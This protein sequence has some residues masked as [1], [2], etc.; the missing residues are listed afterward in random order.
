MSLET[1]R[2]SDVLV[3]ILLFFS[4]LSFNTSSAPET[5]MC[6]DQKKNETKDLKPSPQAVLLR[7]SGRATFC[8]LLT[9]YLNSPPASSASLPGHPALA[10]FR[11]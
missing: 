9:A 6:L 4:F 3:G 2:S 10:R 5:Q 1:T 8:T 11:L 7:N